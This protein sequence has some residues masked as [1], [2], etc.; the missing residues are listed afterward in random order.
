MRVYVWYVHGEKRYIIKSR[1]KNFALEGKLDI[2]KK[3]ID[4]TP[5]IPLK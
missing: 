3:C 1:A 5:K 4:N 2:I